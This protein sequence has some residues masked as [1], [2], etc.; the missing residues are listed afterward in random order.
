M[1]A[2]KTYTLTQFAQALGQSERMTL[3]ASKPF[4]VAYTKAEPAQQKEMRDEWVIAYVQGRLDVPQSRAAKIVGMTREERTAK[5]EDW[6]KAVN[7]AGQKFTYHVVNHGKPGD[8]EGSGRNE[9]AGKVR[10]S[11]V[12]KDAALE[13]IEVFDGDDKAAKISAAIK[14]L[15]A[16][17]ARLA[18]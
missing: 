9:P 2:S 17:K 3:D 15:K 7:A 11:S 6:E 14:A 12:Q 18:K 4:H 8:R 1:A 5:N 16:L 13:F 10:V